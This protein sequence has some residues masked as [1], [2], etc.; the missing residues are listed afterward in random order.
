MARMASEEHFP[1]S[2]EPV[3]FVGRQSCQA[4]LP[5]A[6][7]QSAYSGAAPDYNIC[8]IA[9]ADECSVSVRMERPT[10]ESQ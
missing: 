6:D 7:F 10:T 1:A 3:G 2:L 9:P 5:A 4:I 8:E